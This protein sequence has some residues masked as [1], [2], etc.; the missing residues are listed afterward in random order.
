MEKDGDIFASFVVD[1]LVRQ[2]LQISQRVL[3]R[4]SLPLKLNLVV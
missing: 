4:T 3:L 1:E 2:Y